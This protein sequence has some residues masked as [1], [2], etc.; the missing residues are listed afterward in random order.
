[1]YDQTTREPYDPDNYRVSG[2]IDYYINEHHSI[3]VGGSFNGR[4]STRI[5]TNEKII[6]IF[7]NFDMYPISSSI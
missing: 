3:G 1:M 6:Y 2:N 4:N 5:V 7:T